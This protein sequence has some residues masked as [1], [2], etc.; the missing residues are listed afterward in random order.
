[1]RDDR[2]KGKQCRKTVRSWG[3][4]AAVMLMTAGVGAM[5]AMAAGP[6]TRVAL[7]SPVVDGPAPQPH[8]LTARVDI[9]DQTMTVYVDGRLT[10]TFPVSTGGGRYHTPTGS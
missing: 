5:P 1:M 8:I 3:L 9:S 10:E 6:G 7:A 2:D 4:G